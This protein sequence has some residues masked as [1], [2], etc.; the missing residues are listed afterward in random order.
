[1]PS[2]GS[3]PISVVEYAMEI[4]KTTSDIDH[5][6]C[7]FDRDFHESY[8]RAIKKLEDYK[9]KRKDKSKPIYKAIT[10]TPCFEIWLLLHF[11]YTTKSYSHAEHVIQDLCKVLSGY[12]KKNALW[13]K[14]LI[15]KIDT[16]IRNATK[17]VEHNQKTNTVNP[18][19]NMHE[20][21]E[22]LRGLTRN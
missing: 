1:M 11:L 12:T 16:A 13:F 18:A 8:D 10:T 19:T 6:V 3:A 22:K 21:I 4:A 14:Q 7:V 20:I 9:P 2:T 5:M 17:L 15:D